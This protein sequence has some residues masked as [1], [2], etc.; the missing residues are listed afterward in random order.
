[1]SFPVKPA[2]ALRFL[3][4]LLCNSVIRPPSS[5]RIAIT[6][7]LPPRGHSVPFLPNPE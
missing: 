7:S 4:F 3:R 6:L 2:S 5:D 1:M